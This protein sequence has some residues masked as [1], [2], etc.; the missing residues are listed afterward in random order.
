[1]KNKDINLKHGYI[2]LTSIFLVLFSIALSIEI[3]LKGGFN[4]VIHSVETQ[5]SEDNSVSDVAEPTLSIISLQNY[6]RTKNSSVTVVAQ[7]EAQNKGFINGKEV[8]VNEE[9]IFE[10]QI[11][12]VIGTNEVFIEVQ[13][14][15]GTS[16]SEVIS[17]IR[18]EEQ[19][20]EPLPEVKQEQ[21]ETETSKSEQ[22]PEIMKPIESKQPEQYQLTGLKLT[23]SITNTQPFVGQSVSLDCLVK[24]QNNNPVSG[25][26]GSAVVN[27][28]SGQTTYNFPSSS[29]GSTRIDFTVPEGNIGLIVG[30]V[31]ISK[32]GLTVTSNFSIVVK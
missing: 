27:W 9:G 7:T 28:Q 29:N 15:N 2:F 32:D 24:N 22:K 21:P 1:M 17:I 25:A 18:E 8:L 3:Y 12:L 13:N 6:Y 10:L 19:K 14:P 4:S 30:A 31:R 16:K 23:C 11:E 20:E 5:N 26:T